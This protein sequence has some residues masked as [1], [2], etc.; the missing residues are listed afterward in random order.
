MKDVAPDSLRRTRIDPQDLPE[1][2]VLVDQTRERTSW[3]EG[4]FVT[5]AQFLRDQ[6]YVI[7]RHADVGRAIGA[8]VIT[9][10]E[11]DQ[12]GD[13]PTALRVAPGLGLG[14]GG[15][16][17]VLNE[18]VTLA[19]ADTALQKGLTKT[20]G[21]SESLKLISEARTGLF[22]LCASPVEYTSNPQAMYST[23]AGGKRKLADS[24]VTEATLF[25]LVPFALGSGASSPQR[26]RAVAAHRV[27]IE[28][29]MADLPPSS[30]PLAMLELDGNVLIWL[31]MP[32]VRRDA[33][34]SR[35]D[36]FGLGIVDTAAR[37]AHSAQYEAQIAQM[38]ASSPDQAVPASQRFD[39]LPPMGRMP[40]AC[41][42]QRAPAPGLRPVLS[43]NWLPAEM[44]VELTA[45]PEDEIDQL[46]EESLTMPPL[47]LRASADAM[48]QT[49]VTIIVPIP[50]A[51]WAEAPLE[52]V[53][54]PLTLEAAAPLGKQPKTPMA[55]IEALLE[56]NEDPDQVDPTDAAPWLGLLAGRA[57]LWY[58]RRRQFLRTDALT[59]K[60]YSFQ[61]G[62]GDDNRGDDNDGD[63][64][65]EPPVE[66]QPELRRTLAALS[67]TLGGAAS[68]AI[69]DLGMEE[70]LRAIAIP[71][72]LDGTRAGAT[73][74]ARL[75]DLIARGSDLAATDLLW[76]A[77]ESGA[78]SEAIANNLSRG[79]AFERLSGNIAPIEALL[80]GGP[81]EFVIPAFKPA[82]TPPNI[83][84]AFARVANGGTQ[85]EAVPRPNTP[86]DMQDRVMRFVEEAEVPPEVGRAI[87]IRGGGPVPSGRYR[88]ID[89]R[90]KVVEI[91]LEL[92]MPIAVRLTERGSVEAQ[93]RRNLLARSKQVQAVMKRLNENPF[94]GR[95]VDP[96]MKHAE[97]LDEALTSDPNRAVALVTETLAEIAG[98]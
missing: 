50:R 2:A 84:R 12:P 89:A 4:M 28:G 85:P 94:D 63:G 64:G 60:A 86:N 21:M 22:V 26:R 5:S 53:Q 42:A 58:M 39:V 83:T 20:A 73:V 10:L 17:I 32:M 87:L 97:L 65:D 61:I 35:A 3:E 51:K 66:P 40:A 13:N 56:Q 95:L 44:P 88:D 76:R 91:A 72:T 78:L 24:V 59:G 62:D 19:L 43:H 74:L 36:A 33:G 55:L 30:L 27:F 79:Y 18:A 96:V 45:L 82:E 92:G 41:V 23:T 6:S 52:I 93:T 77:E 25:T 7:A 57:T 80:I 46:L 8:G 98:S 11:V 1:G 16:S 15:E 71:D 68:S 67:E 37:I 48:A 29:A 70:H 9:G 47:D 54:Q 49:P 81:V 75:T 90:R 34:A 14:G 31:D 38:V 69:V